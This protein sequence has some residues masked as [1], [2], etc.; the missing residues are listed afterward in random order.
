LS[1]CL[2]AI[3]SQEENKSRFLVG[4]YTSKQAFLHSINY[5]V[6]KNELNIKEVV[7]FEK[8]EKNDMI[9]NDVIGIYSPVHLEDMHGSNNNN[10]MSFFIQVFNE[11]DRKYQLKM[12][13]NI[14]GGEGEILY[15]DIK[16]SHSNLIFE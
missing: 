2:K 4:S 15:N 16:A 3:P 6:E 13:K 7:N 9:F 12:L 8:A 14:D 10:E 11:T 1:R 5:D